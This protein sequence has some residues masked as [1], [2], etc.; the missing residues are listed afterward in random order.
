MTTTSHS[1]QSASITPLPL[2]RR[3]GPDRR[4]HR[5]PPLR[6]LLFG[7]RRQSVRREE[8]KGC[9]NICDRYQPRVMITGIAIV[10]LS[11]LDAVLTLILIENGAT[12]INPVMAFFLRM[13]PGVFMVTKYGLTSFSVLVLVIFN[14]VFLRKLKIYA[15]TVLSYLAWVLSSV[16]VWELL[17]IVRFVL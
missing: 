5:I 1:Q 4:K 16:I 15:S 13:G 17:L 14:N 2:E 12:E 9:L 8:D 10:V 6:W 11:I 7:G 3:R